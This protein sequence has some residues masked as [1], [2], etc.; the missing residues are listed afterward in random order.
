MTI[1]A[2]E[3]RINQIILKLSF[4][5]K[6]SNLSGSRKNIY[7]IFILFYSAFTKY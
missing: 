5:K 4:S 6:V 2:E 3:T 1:L 7:Q